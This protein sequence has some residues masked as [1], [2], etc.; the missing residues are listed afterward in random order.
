MNSNDLFF[1]E[2]L[3]HQIGLRRVE[4]S[5]R[6]K[7]IALLDATESHLRGEIAHRLEALVVEGGISF[8]PVELK[9][10]QAL[11][12]FIGTVRGR[13]FVDV[14]KEWRT[15]FAE[16]AVAEPGFMIDA[17]NASI[18]VTVNWAV[19]AVEQLTA[20]VTTNPFRGKVLREW[21][22]DIGRADI[23]RI[24]AEI[25]IG[26]TEG[27]TVQ[28]ISRRVFGTLADKGTSGVT[29][30]TRRQATAITRTAVTHYSNAAKELFFL[31]NK[32]II[33]REIYTATLDG[34]TCWSG[35]TLILMADGTQ[36][37]IK[38]LMAGH[39]IIGGISG[40]PCK[41]MSICSTE[42]SHAINI[43]GV[44]RCTPDHRIL[45]SSGWRRAEDL[46]LPDNAGRKE[47]AV[48]RNIKV[49]SEADQGACLLKSASIEPCDHETWNSISEDPFMRK[50]LRD[51]V[52]ERKGFDQ[53]VEYP[54][55]EWLQRDEGRG[56]DSL[57]IKEEANPC[58]EESSENEIS[59]FNTGG[60]IYVSKESE[61][62]VDSIEYG[63]NEICQSETITRSRF[64]SQSAK[65]HAA[66]SCTADTGDGGGCDTQELAR[67]RMPSKDECGPSERIQRAQ[68][69]AK[70]NHS[71]S[72]E[73]NHE[74]EMGRS[75]VSR[76]GTEV[77]QTYCSEK[78]I[79]GTKKEGRVTIYS[80][81]IEGDHSY[82][83]GGL[84]VHNTPICQ[85]LDGK[86]FPVGEG[87]RPPMHFQCRSV[88]LALLDKDLLGSRPSNP[89]TEKR[90]LREF[91]TKE[92]IKT[93]TTR[94]NL[95]HGT[96]GRFDAFSRTRKRELIGTVPAKVTYQQWLKRQPVHVQNDILGVTK[97]KLFRNGGLTLDRFVDR[98]GTELT[99]VKL[100]KRNPLAFK[101]AGIN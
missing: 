92:N 86:I 49:S 51:C 62:G 1:D 44:G 55:A 60:T 61:I 64:F 79:R 63:Q 6:N 32:D 65:E 3:R 18:P 72:E 4:G 24:N 2:V 85:S 40:K 14:F 45:T 9:R 21:S 30:I 101:Q 76:K 33:K 59:E 97:G 26:L 68:S 89:A 87:P 39:D 19:P 67:P 81:T 78:E 71:I 42:E 96:K 66:C 31:E 56:R 82:V 70:S 12:E 84:V 7:I 34:R 23:A 80:L 11:E 50:I 77:A 99:L 16:I 29:A 41:V 15:S 48:C 57:F 93:V 52:P 27:Q 94:K 46:C 58:S 75:C 38:Q 25:K 37:P 69:R 8:T 28:E 43:E 98:R 22:K 47:K 74:S 20:L 90:L 17:M 35:D 53:G 100:K 73:R 10:L 5:I 91:S 88:R 54:C 95:P 83:A 13:A 36:K